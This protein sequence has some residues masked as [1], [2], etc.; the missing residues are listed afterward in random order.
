M[1][2]STTPHYVNATLKN[3]YY[4]FSKWYIFQYKQMYTR[5]RYAGS[6][7]QACGLIG[8]TIINYYYP[9]NCTRPQP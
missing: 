5:Q 4:N 3:Y 8:N 9:E 1:H 2:T 6:G 7:Y